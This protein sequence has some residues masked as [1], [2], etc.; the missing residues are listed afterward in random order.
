MVANLVQLQDKLK[1]LSDMQLRDIYSKGTVPQFLVMTEMGRRKEMQEEYQ[2]S[3][4]QQATTVAQDLMSPATDMARNIGGM[5]QPQN[6]MSMQG[7]ELPIEQ[8][9]TTMP[10]SPQSMA[11]KLPVTSMANGGLAKINKSSPRKMDIGGALGMS[12]MTPVQSRGM[13]PF[14]SSMMRPPPDFNPFGGGLKEELNEVDADL[15]GLSEKIDDVGAYAER[16]GDILARGIE[17]Q[18]ENY[19]NNIQGQLGTGSYNNP[20]QRFLDNPRGPRPI[21]G[22]GGVRMGGPPLDLTEV[23]DPQPANINQQTQQ[24]MADGGLAKIRAQNGFFARPVRQQPYPQTS[25]SLADQRRLRME[26][27]RESAA[28]SNP[29]RSIIDGITPRDVR[30]TLSPSQQIKY[31]QL[32]TAQ[33]DDINL[34]K[35]LF[36]NQPDLQLQYIQGASPNI[37]SSGGRGDA[38]TL[39]RMA[40]SDLSTEGPEGGLASYDPFY[41]FSP[42]SINLSTQMPYPSADLSGRGLTYSTG[43]GP[44]ELSD[45]LRQM[46]YSQTLAPVSPDPVATPINATMRKVMANAANKTTPAG[47]QVNPKPEYSGAPSNKEV[48]DQTTGLSARLE[49]VKGKQFTPPTATQAATDR[50]AATNKALTEAQAAQTGDSVYKDLFANLDK[51]TTASEDAGDEALGLALLDAALR[52]AGSK[53]PS[54]FQALGEAAPAVRGY[55][56][57]KAEIRKEQNSLLDSRAKLTQLKLAETQG[58]KE[59]VRKIRQELRQINQD[60]AQI[61]DRAFKRFTDERTLNLNLI[62]AESQLATARS[63]EKRENAKIG[64]Q[65][66]QLAISKN[67]LENQAGEISLNIS[68]LKRDLPRLTGQRKLQAEEAIKLNEE[69]LKDV[70]KTIRATKTPSAYQQFTDQKFFQ[71]RAKTIDTLIKNIKGQ[72]GTRKELFVTMQTGADK[73]PAAKQAAEKRWEDA[74][75]QIKVLEDEKAEVVRRLTGGSPASPTTP[76]VTSLEDYRNR[77]PAQPK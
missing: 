56:K 40:L 39:S 8:S 18:I 47:I 34:A 28:A 35:E 15:S 65:N 68:N 72:I 53:S 44:V 21:A 70:T 76:G 9:M 6:R 52:V 33:Y 5:A 17:S 43:M 66:A 74:Q 2:R 3:Q 27:L 23:R 29:M 50:I 64:I 37:V 63:T 67:K 42:E 32:G 60:Q 51:R 4:Q 19:E 22:K 1:D 12:S 14:A 45:P 16:R 61:E 75:N 11:N 31:D 58:N 7:Q 13:T 26:A 59:E 48:G 30:P 10:M 73:S 54:A 57:T 38:G 69:R 71:T 41:G 62:R 55:A 49:E 36:P 25:L 20:Y 77:V 24:T 46:P